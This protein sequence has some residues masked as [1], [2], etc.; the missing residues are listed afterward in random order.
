MFTCCTDTMIGSILS[1][2]LCVAMVH[3]HSQPPSGMCGGSV[4]N[5]V[6]LCQDSAVEGRRQIADKIEQ[7]GQKL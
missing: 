2:L 5:N 1:L 3:V 6:A 7:L 4:Q